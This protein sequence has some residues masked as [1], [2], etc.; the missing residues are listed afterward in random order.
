MEVE[1]SIP[2]YSPLSPVTAVLILLTPHLPDVRV[3]GNKMCLL[4][5]RRPF[6]E[7]DSWIQEVLL[8]V[9]VQRSH[10]LLVMHHICGE[11][12]NPEKCHRKVEEPV[13]FHATIYPLLAQPKSMFVLLH[14]RSLFLDRLRSSTTECSCCAIA[15]FLTAI[16]AV[17]SELYRD[18]VLC[19][20]Q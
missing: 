17:G 16:A 6:A 15:W 12:L 20:P 1:V 18:L 13:K 19:K 8:W 11:P 4:E 14:P 3:G 7:L 5:G 2:V 10:W 9:S